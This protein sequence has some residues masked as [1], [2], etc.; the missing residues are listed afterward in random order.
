MEVDIAAALIGLAGAIIAALVSY[1]AAREK[2]A[3]EHNNMLETMRKEIV[4]N[5]RASMYEQQIEAHKKIWTALRLASYHAPDENSII[6]R[7]DDGVYLNAPVAREIFARFQEIFYSESGIF[8]AKN[9]R[10]AIFKV[11]EFVFDLLAEAG[12]NENG[13]VKISNTKAKKVE[14]GFDWVRK[15][16][17]R[18][19]GLEDL[20]L[21]EDA[22]DDSALNAR[23]Q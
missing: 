23:K 17:R 18:D 1:I 3:N 4:F 12:E 7:H 8:I 14:D 15:N 10:N 13:L 22:K 19:I 9:T 16:I 5:L 11:R 21:P 20:A 6:V 2:I